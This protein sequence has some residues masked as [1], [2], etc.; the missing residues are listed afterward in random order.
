MLLLSPRF[1]CHRGL[2]SYSLSGV[3]AVVRP[4]LLQGIIC[5][6]ATTHVDS[7]SLFSVSSRLFL[8]VNIPVP[9]SV[10]FVSVSFHCYYKIPT[11][12]PSALPPFPTPSS[13]TSSFSSL[14]THP[15]LIHMCD[16]FPLPLRFCSP[17]RPCKLRLTVAPR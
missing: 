10:S 5:K 17:V 12:T 2:R 1:C 4:R 7:F 13:L 11:P 14:L 3:R 9:V 15:S 16:V 8:F 6:C